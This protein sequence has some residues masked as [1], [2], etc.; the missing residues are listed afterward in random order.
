MVFYANE[1]DSE[2]GFLQGVFD[3]L[4]NYLFYFEL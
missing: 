1:N 3:F 2:N 4:N